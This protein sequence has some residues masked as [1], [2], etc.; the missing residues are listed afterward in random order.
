MSYDYDYLVKIL[1]IGDGS[2]GKTSTVR[3]FVDDDFKKKEI[4]KEEFMIKYMEIGDFGENENNKNNKNNKNNNNNNYGKRAKLIIKEERLE[5]YRIGRNEFI[6]SDGFLLFFD[7]T[8]RSSYINL[9]NWIEEI[10]YRTRRINNDELPPIVIVGNKIDKD[11]YSIKVSHEEVKDFCDT[12]SIPFIFI[13]AKFN[14]NVELSFTTLQNLILKEKY[15]PN[16]LSI[17]SSSS[18]SLSINLNDVKTNNNNNNN[19][20]NT[21]KDKCNIM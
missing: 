13:S 1:M 8:D 3:R 19:N 11:E 16:Q 20:T 17:P 7:V 9:S 4:P 2:V 10:K 6:S 14:E 5:K 15:F 21:N 12:R 18:S